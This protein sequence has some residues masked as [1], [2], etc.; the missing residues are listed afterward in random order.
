MRRLF[1][2]C[3]CAVAVFFA[4][5]VSSA[6]AVDIIE[7]Q[8]PGRVVE[9]PEAGLQAGLC[10]ED[11][12]S[13]G[14]KC[15]SATPELFFE[16][17]AGHPADAFTQI[18]VKH[19]EA[20]KAPAGSAKTFL[21][22]LPAGLSVNA[23]A[24]PQC[25]LVIKE[26]KEVFP[27][28]GCPADTQVGVSEVAVLTSVSLGS[29][30]VYNIKPRAG[31]PARFGFAI[32]GIIPVF[33]NAGVAWQSDYHEY[34]TIH[35]PQL[36]LAL[37]KNRLFF[38]GTTGQEGSGGAF[39]TLP[40]TC[41]SAAVEP[42]RTAYATTVHADSVAEEAPEDEYDVLAPA[43]PPPAF[44]AG[45]QEVVGYLPKA[46]A[47]TGCANV[48]FQPTASTEAG[49][50]YTDSPAPATVEVAMPFEPHAD[51]YQSN[52]KTAKLSL[53]QGMGLNPAAAPG[54]GT[55]DEG[56]FPTH[57]REAISCP[58]DSR[59]GSVELE[60]PV[61]PKG[62]L[63][64]SVYLAKPEGNDPESG[65]LYRLFLD[66]S[67]AERGVSVRLVAGIS[68]N[69]T[70]GK[71]TATIENAPQV[72]FESF[73]IKLDGKETSPL[74]SPSTCGP[75]VTTHDFGAW[76]GSPD[77][78]ATA[79]GF[80]LSAS[81]TGGNCAKTGAE[82]PFSPAFASAP[83]QNTAK[84]ATNYTL[85]VE[86][87]DGE[88]ELKGIDVTLPPGETARLKGVAYCPESAIAAA[89]ASTAK[90]QINAPSCPDSSFIGT[91]KIA[92]GAGGSPLQLAGNAYL[93]GPY[94]G[95]P[96]SMVIVTP[97]LAG[98][99]DLG[100]VV[101]HAAVFVEPESGQI[102]VV[103]D[104]IPDTVGGAKV[105]LRSLTV[106]LS[107]KFFFR[108]GTSCKASG[109]TGSLAGGGNDP[110]NAAD[111]TSHG[112]SVGSW[113]EGCK[114]LQFKPRLKL[115]L[116]GQTKRAGHPHLKA[117]LSARSGKDADV[118]SL[119]VA[120]PHSLFLDQAS[121]GTVCTRV[122]F[123]AQQCPTKSIYGHATAWSPLL[124][125]PITGPVYLRS[126]SNKLPDLVAHLQGQVNIDLDGRIDSYKGGIRTSFESVPDLPVSKF[127]LNLPGGKGGLLVASQNLCAAPVK[128]E[129]KA[130]AHNSRVAHLNQVVKPAGCKS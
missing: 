10:T 72:P 108:N 37:F 97:A 33:L 82:R 102:H 32:L 83:A 35:V 3:L 1:F 14:E 103:S 63:K 47:S 45:S 121:L 66:A 84:A 89:T 25:E 46:A 16:Q 101:V 65:K 39:L 59:L 17:A 5:F 116:S 74:T 24:T 20:T 71:L 38:D 105:D 125:Q 15:S 22:G 28:G 113:L 21:V 118:G 119:S 40:S 36:G 92:A 117:V 73:R 111:F 98:P 55:C 34:F 54:L 130:V 126:S 93:A 4:L 128:A 13:A 11:E 110:S 51:V 120:L 100:D 23:E 70:T 31:E 26:G 99:F 95:A 127:E 87:K 96:L 27:P 90:A 75:N 6:G 56:Q 124:E 79:P 76:S 64:G 78:G 30:P 58:A 122:Q 114:A 69:K 44:L 7:S 49:T 123:A 112:V 53:P 19:N 52:V 9:S 67:S 42:F 129:V 88:Q 12:N 68:A 61:L 77:N 18:I 107:R 2:G 57:T 41:G 81:P 8:E 115:S 94:K 106:E 62:S 85:K 50:T 60:T 80:N 86:R 43:F 48:P 104:P 91:V 29:T 109:V